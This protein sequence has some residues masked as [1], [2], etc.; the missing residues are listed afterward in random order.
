MSNN[1]FTPVQEQALN[2]L[3]VALAEARGALELVRWA[4]SKE[5]QANELAYDAEREM[6]C[7]L[8]LLSDSRLPHSSSGTLCDLYEALL[9]QAKVTRAFGQ[10]DP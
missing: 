2:N 3:A 7:R 10:V 9:K 6:F 1:P 8:S 4:F 5:I